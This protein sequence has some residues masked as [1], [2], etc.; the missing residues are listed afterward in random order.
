LVVTK[1]N[2]FI[3]FEKQ[4]NEPSRRKDVRRKLTS[5]QNCVRISSNREV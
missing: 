5:A 4:M 1:I 2:K 3:C